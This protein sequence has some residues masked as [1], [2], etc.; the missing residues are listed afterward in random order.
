MDVL[1]ANISLDWLKAL[2][3]VVSIG[4]GALLFYV[5]AHKK[6]WEVVTATLFGLLS[7][8]V[9]FL[10]AN[11][12]AANYILSHA[13]DP[14]W[15]VGKSPVWTPTPLDPGAL[16][17]LNDFVNSLNDTQNNI[18]GAV[19]TVG[20]I[21]NAVEVASLFFQQ[22]AWS[23]LAVIVLGAVTVVASKWAAKRA[24]KYKDRELNANLAE[25]RAELGMPP[26]KMPKG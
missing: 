5:S 21:D 26:F 19:N 4:I 17:F 2:V 16:V 6:Y 23:V 11:L 20:A 7:A 15:S 3:W 18:A 1:L 22:L 14:R 13:T 10:L 12:G 9:T 24:A 8:S 25:I